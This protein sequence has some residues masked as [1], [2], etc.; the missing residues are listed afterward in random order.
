MAG[1][2]VVNNALM[3]LVR[4][5]HFVWLMILCH[6]IYK[7]AKSD[8]VVMH[9][10]PR[11]TCAWYHVMRCFVFP[12][13]KFHSQW[14]APCHSVVICCNVMSCRTQGGRNSPRGRQGSTSSIFQVG[15]HYSY[16]SNTSIRTECFVWSHGIGQS[17]LKIIHALNHTTVTLLFHFF[18]HDKRKKA[19]GKWY[20]HENGSS[21]AHVGGDIG[22]SNG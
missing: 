17:A 11:S 5:K 21:K 9:P 13:I 8:M 7:Q 10:L 6:M 3:A 19:N 20:V 1:S 22:A 15:A 14:M 18:A 4:K 12:L 2:Y 16:Q